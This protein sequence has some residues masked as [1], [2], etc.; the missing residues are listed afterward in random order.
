MFDRLVSG[1]RGLK[2]FFHSGYRTAKSFLGDVDSAFQAGKK[3]YSIIEP[4]LRDLA[5]NAVKNVNKHV[6]KGIGE[7]ENLR[8]QVMETHENAINNVNQVYGN[9]KKANL[10]IP[11]LI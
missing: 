10:K 8:S 3:I 5:P 9:L 6:V 7:Y 1:T 2:T 4:V 11:G